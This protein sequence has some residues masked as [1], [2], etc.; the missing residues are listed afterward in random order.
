MKRR[1]L[2]GIGSFL[3]ALLDSRWPFLVWVALGCLAMGVISGS[4]AYVALLHNIPLNGVV[5][6]FGPGNR[7]QRGNVHMEYVS[8]LIV[9]SCLGFAGSIISLAIWHRQNQPKSVTR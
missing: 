9:Y 8:T 6:F 4:D 7:I 1:V 5:A 2:N 3:W